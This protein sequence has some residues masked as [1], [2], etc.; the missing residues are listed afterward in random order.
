MKKYII[1]TI[2]LGFVCL[3]VLT[4][5]NNSSDSTGSTPAMTNAPA[6]PAMT[7]APAATNT[8]AQ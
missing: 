3:G 5:C 6:A 2:A 1:L 4:G 7:N 8:P